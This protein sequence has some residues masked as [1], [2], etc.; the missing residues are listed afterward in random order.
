MDASKKFAD[1][2]RLQEAAFIAAMWAPRG[3]KRN[4]KRMLRLADANLRVATKEMLAATPVDAS[5][6]SMSDDELLAALG[7]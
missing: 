5:I 2:D 3:M 7:V 6:D 1:A 4:A